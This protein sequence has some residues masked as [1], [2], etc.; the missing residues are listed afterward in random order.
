MNTLL[1]THTDL[2]GISVLVLTRYFGVKFKK[3]YVWNYEEINIDD[4]K[5]YKNIIMVDLSIDEKS[6]LD[7][8][9]RGC[10][11]R[12]YDHHETSKYI[13]KYKGNI[14]DMNRCGT[15]IFYDNYIKFLPMFKENKSVEDYVLLVDTFDRWQQNNPLWERAL[16]L[17]RLFTSTQHFINIGVEYIKR[18]LVFTPSESM[19]IIQTIHDEDK[20]YKES[21]RGMKKYTDSKGVIYGV[22]PIKKY[23]SIV[24]N[25]I[26][27]NNQ[28]LVY[29]IGYYPSGRISV[30][31]VERF[32][33]TT[34][35]GIHGHKNAGGGFMNKNEIKELINGTY[36]FYN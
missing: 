10:D 28:D 33:V 18:N 12:I 8:K 25:R 7:L 34:L 21:I 32:D 5:K 30:R 27:N 3:V 31:S 36:A 23:V 1:I 17:Q 4:M 29:V 14:W 2:D 24:C 15:R 11:I 6:F 19:T 22:I 9:Q 13:S 20:E 35:K 16:N 26:L